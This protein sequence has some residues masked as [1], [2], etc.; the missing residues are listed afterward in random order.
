VSEAWIK[1]LVKTL[2]DPKVV[3]LSSDAARWGWIAILLAAK[4]QSPQGHFEGEAHLRAV[5]SPSV[6]EHIEELV[7]KGLLLV[8]PEGG[9]SPARWRRYQVDPTASDRQRRARD[10]DARDGSVT[11][12][13]TGRDSHAPEKERERE[14]EKETI[15]K[16]IGVE[17]IAAVVDRVS[18]RAR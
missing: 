7:Q 2:R 15:R 11:K 18:R 9:I 5:V 8:D 17:S 10:R 14:R 3:T 13:V 6:G 4:E 16:E 1:V 12:I